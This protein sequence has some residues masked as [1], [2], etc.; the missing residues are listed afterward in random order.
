MLVGDFFQISTMSSGDG[1][2]DVVL[3]INALHKIFDGHFPGQ[4]VV[5]GVCMLQ[6]VK[7]VLDKELGSETRLTSADYLKFLTIINP[8]K[9]NIIHAEIKYVIEDDRRIILSATLLNE[10]VIYFKMK[11]VMVIDKLIG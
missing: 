3:E 7:E 10:L 8:A 9:N 2:I 11:G 6:M 4:P 5:P 1:R